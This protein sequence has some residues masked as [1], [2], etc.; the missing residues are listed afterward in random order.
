MD[1]QGDV[2]RIPH[3]CLYP[4][5]IWKVNLPW[6]PS[7]L[8]QFIYHQIKLSTIYQRFG[9][10]SPVNH[11]NWHVN[12]LQDHFSYLLVTYHLVLINKCSCTLWYLQNKIHRS[13]Q[14]VSS[15]LH[16]QD[17]TQKD[18]ISSLLS[19]Q[20][21]LL[22]AFISW[23]F[24]SAHLCIYCTVLTLEKQSTRYFNQFGCH[25]VTCKNCRPANLPF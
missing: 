13:Y 23:L 24:I 1:K 7:L 19:Y 11:I 12:V 6:F 16:P 18:I 3:F 25:S 10:I 21:K 5:C 8:P 17:C 22:I 4:T 9:P 14:Q 2:R 20:H 15:K